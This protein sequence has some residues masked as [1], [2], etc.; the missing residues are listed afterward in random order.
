VRRVDSGLCDDL[1]TRSESVCVCVR[2]WVCVSLCDLGSPRVRWPRPD[3]GCCATDKNGSKHTAVCAL[4]VSTSVNQHCITVCSSKHASYDC[5]YFQGSFRNTVNWDLS[6]LQRIQA[7]LRELKS[8]RDVRI[9]RL[10]LYSDPWYYHELEQ[11]FLYLK[12]VTCIEKWLYAT[13][14]TSVNQ[15]ILL[16]ETIVVC[17]ENR[18]KHKCTVLQKA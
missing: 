3:F 8:L 2:A 7:F 6:F 11:L 15:L 1:I 18:T 12:F 13:Y 9:S 5:H 10:T 16:L 4:R 14:K 17:R